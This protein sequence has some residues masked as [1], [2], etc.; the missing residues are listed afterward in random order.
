MERY[1]KNEPRLT[2]FRKLDSDESDSNPWS[3]VIS[4]STDS[5]RDSSAV[6]Q[7]DDS[8]GFPSVSFPST[9]SAFF[10]S[11]SIWPFRLHAAGDMSPARGG[12]G[13]GGDN[14]DCPVSPT[15]YSKRDDVTN[16]V[17]N[18][19]W[20]NMNDTVQSSSSSG[21]S[22]GVSWDSN[23]SGDQD[24]LPR[25]KRPFAIR[26][27]SRPQRLTPFG[28]AGSSSTA[29]DPDSASP[30]RPP[31]PPSAPSRLHAL[32][33]FFQPNRTNAREA[34]HKTDGGS[35]D[36]PVIDAKKRIYRCSY[37]GCEKIYT[38]S[39]HLKAHLRSHTGDYLL[40]S[41]LQIHYQFFFRTRLKSHLF[42]W[43]INHKLST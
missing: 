34:A 25:F 41:D 17:E 19:A 2:S 1:L 40:Y 23:R 35:D 10:S 24:S 27:V 39:S 13:G 37:A 7:T 5:F 32:Q 36:V 38:K 31:P 16:P 8:V 43:I 26:L 11:S 14:S 9:A 3:K 21:A 33:G 22:S 15:P 18:L 29:A 4:R 12:G 30:S 6:D 20:L 28:Y 42:D